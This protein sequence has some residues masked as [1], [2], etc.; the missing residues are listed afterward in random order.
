MHKIIQFLQALATT[1]D[2]LVLAQ[3]LDV[4]WLH[5]LE[6]IGIINA[7]EPNLIYTD[8][9]TNLSLTRSLD[10]MNQT[11]IRQLLHQSNLDNYTVHILDDV[12]STNSYI[13]NN[14]Y[15]LSDRVVVSTEFQTHGRGR[16]DKAW[17]SKIALDLTVSFLYVFPLDFNYE[18][19]SLISAI[20]INRLLKQYHIKNYIKWP[21]DIYSADKIKLAGILTESGVRDAQRFVVIGIG[22]N[23]NVEHQFKRD[24]LLVH[25]IQHMDNVVLEY[26]AFGFALLRQEWLDNCLHYKQQVTLSK[27]TQCIDKGINVDLNILG[28]IG[29][30]SSDTIT[31]YPSG[32]ISLQV[33][34]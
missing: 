32:D 29:I 1:N 34:P 3:K 15:T 11:R 23:N 14:L 18:L 33:Q 12:P 28:Q 9:D 20:A 8:C 19:L 31:Y 30:K 26:S 5:V 16:G 27:N 21:N 2:R 25:L 6:M 22:L 13:L 17:H 24:A 7:I 4:T 10:W